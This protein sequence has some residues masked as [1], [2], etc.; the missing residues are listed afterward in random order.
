MN[1]IV[2]RGGEIKDVAI[3]FPERERSRE[4]AR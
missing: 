2:K 1:R 3:E 4:R